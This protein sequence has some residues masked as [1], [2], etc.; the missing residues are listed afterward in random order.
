MR[1]DNIMNFSDRLAKAIKEKN[2]PT[3]LGLD[4]KLEFIPDSI[5]KACFKDCDCSFKAAAKVLLNLT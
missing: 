4:P 5:K 1:G 2:N 3:V